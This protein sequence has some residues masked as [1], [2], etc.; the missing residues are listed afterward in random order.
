MRVVLAGY[1]VDAE[2]I[3]LVKKYLEN[4]EDET[5][6]MRIEEMLVNEPWTPETLSAA[7]ARISRSERSIREL[8]EEARDS[9][10]RARKSNERI[11]FEFGHSS[12]AEHAVFN[13]EISNVSRLALEFLERHRL[14]SYTEASQRFIWM[15]EEFIVPSEIKGT[16]FEAPYRDLCHALFEGYRQLAGK[17]ERS[18]TSLSERERQGRARE[19]ARYLLP[20]S[21]KT[22]V[23]VSLNARSAE[24][25]ASRLGGS[26]LE[27]VR[28]MGEKIAEAIKEIA[29]SLLRYHSPIEDEYDRH[30]S[31]TSFFSHWEG[32]TEA[33]TM[34]SSSEG[35][36]W[37][38]EECG[39]VRCLSW[40]PEGELLAIASL[41]F[42]VVPRRFSEIYQ[43]VRNLSEDQKKRLVSMASARLTPHHP[44]W[45]GW[46]LGYFIYEVLLSASAYAQLKRHRISTQ[47]VQEYQPS[48]GVT[49]PPSVKEVGEE[50]M[51]LE[52][53]GR[54]DRLY[55]EL[56]RN[57]PP[58]KRAAAQY[59]LTN[60]H[61]R[62]IIFSA[63]AR[64]LV[65]LSR[66]RED[67]HA[68]WDLRA[69]VKEMIDQ[70]R[71]RSPLLMALA[72]GKDRFQ[73]IKDLLTSW[74]EGD[75]HL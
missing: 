74:R 69:L 51:F 11:I 50:G 62:R 67:K 70:A 8:R 39:E 5:T 48:L 15:G 57:L 75:H 4:R 43:N 64:E 13:L 31:L 44:G 26:S 6:R 59:C 60:A 61:R 54:A 63:N 47:I 66:L 21:C 3:A 10:I 23:G 58:Q 71:Q 16:E 42:E 19:D 29:P 36:E 32:A 52:L 28:E 22:Q 17:L 65:H 35:E 18:F 38:P 27:E 33:G 53:T 1:N 73:E 45:R 72:G 7:F 25:I 14:A 55:S 37:T 46:E 68:Q 9:L 20:L 2:G 24:Y 56:V 12:V 41:L 40:N 34:H 49:I 30:L